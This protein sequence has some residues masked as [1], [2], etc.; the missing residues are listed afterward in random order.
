MGN[1]LK[2]FLLEVE[3][4][5]GEVGGA[6]E[7]A[8]IVLVGAEGEDFVAGGGEVEVGGDDGEDAVFGEEGEEARGDEVDAGEGEGLKRLRGSWMG[9]GRS[10]FASHKTLGGEEVLAALGMTTNGDSGRADDFGGKIAGG[11]AA[12]ELEVGVEEELA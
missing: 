8:P 5:L 12:G 2:N 3:G 7:V 9:F 10:R 11:A 1:L 6:A 4:G